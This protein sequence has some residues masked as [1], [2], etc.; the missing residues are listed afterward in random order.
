MLAFH[1]IATASTFNQ[2]A[3]GVSSDVSEDERIIVKPALTWKTPIGGEL[4]VSYEYNRYRDDYDPGVAVTDDGDSLFRNGPLVGDDSF[5][6]NNNHIGTLT[7]TQPISEYWEFFIGGSYSNL[8]SEALWNF[9]TGLDLGGDPDR[10][11]VIQRTR[12]DQSSEQ[13]E[14][15]GE[16]RGKFSTGAEIDHQVTC[17]VNTY[18]TEPVVI[19]EIRGG[20]ADVVDLFSTSIPAASFGANT[21][22][23]AE[24]L[25]STQ[26][27]LQDFVSIGDNLNVYAGLSFIDAFVRR[28]LT[29]NGATTNDEGED[30][31][32]DWSAGAIYRVA[33][34]FSPFISYSTSLEPQ[35][36]LLPD[37]ELAS[38]REG[39]QIEVGWKS[40]LFD[41]ALLTVSAFDIEQT[42]IA[43][44]NILDPNTVIL[45]GTQRTRGVE[46][47]LVGN[48]TERLSVL[49][50]YSFLDA[51]IIAS[52]TGFEGTR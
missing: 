8:N 39:R 31:S 24:A 2:T 36:G 29:R 12:P 50:G 11:F 10:R 23:F 28:E 32:V 45:V 52:I 34:I 44:G 15:R 18:R 6:Q 21:R 43:E 14:V 3:S 17:G 51:E 38:F 20:V 25:E 37:G 41:N 16:L 19:G 9:G 46:A 30:Q 13:Y 27:Y 47:E 42:N 26:I 33:P 1:L 22:D 7:Y 35:Q 4:Y 48:V 49:A 40:E 5:L